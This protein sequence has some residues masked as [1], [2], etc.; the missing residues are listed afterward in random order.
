NVFFSFQQMISWVSYMSVVST[1]AFVVFFALGPGSIPWLITA[2]LFSQGPRPAAMSIAVLVNWLANFCVGLAFPQLQVL[3]DDYTF[4]PFSVLLAGFWIFTYYLVPET[5]GKTFEEISD[6]FR[7]RSSRPGGFISDYH[8]WLEENNAIKEAAIQEYLEQQQRQ[9]QEQEA[10]K[11]AGSRSLEDPNSCVHYSAPVPMQPYPGAPMGMRPL[12]PLGPDAEGSTSRSPSPSLNLPS[13]QR[14]SI[15]LRG[16]E[17]IYH[18]HPQSVTSGSLERGSSAYHP[19]PPIGTGSL[20]RA[21]SSR[22][23]SSVAQT[24]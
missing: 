12:I 23:P 24:A 14:P 18:P 20:E 16:D 2:E 11:L 15:V 6:L 1:F 4:L 13:Y 8:R 17:A 19:P 9:Q 5:R 21:P 10:D 22:P 3:L 7:N